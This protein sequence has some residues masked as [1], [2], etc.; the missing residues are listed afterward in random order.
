MLLALNMG[1]WARAQE[2]RQSLDGKA[3]EVGFP[4]ELQEWI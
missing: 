3:K 1:E 4:L 2:F